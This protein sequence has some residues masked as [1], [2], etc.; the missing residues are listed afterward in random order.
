MSDL[1][2][3]DM[4]KSFLSALLHN[5]D[6]IPMALSIES[7]AGLMDNDENRQFWKGVIEMHNKD[8]SVDPTALVNHVTKRNYL[9]KQTADSKMAQIVQ[10]QESAANIKTWTEVLS[11]LKNRRN[12]RRACTDAK[13][14]AKN[15]K[16]S[17]Q[18]VRRHMTDRMAE[19]NNVEQASL[20]GDVSLSLIERL[21]EDDFDARSGAI[22][23]G[24]RQLDTIFNGI[25]PQDFIGI[26]SRPGWGKSSLM[27]Q[28]ALAMRVLYPDG[29]I[30]VFSMEMSSDE[31]T[32]RFVSQISGVPFETVFSLLQKGEDVGSTAESKIRTALRTFNKWREEDGGLRMYTGSKTPDQVIQMIRANAMKAEGDKYLG[33]FVDNF[34]RLSKIPM[35]QDKEA[36]VRSFKDVTID[37][38]VPVILLF[39]LNRKCVD[40]QRPPRISDAKSVGQ[41]EQELNRAVIID[42]PDERARF[43]SEDQLREQGIKLNE[44][45][46]DVAKNRD[47]E[48]AS[49]KKF[50]HGP[51]MQ[52]LD[53]KPFGEKAPPAAGRDPIGFGDE[54]DVEPAS[55]DEVEDLFS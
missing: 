17:M 26:L 27:V 8:R 19:T 51:T 52:F 15:M 24:M 42:R 40:E 45:V 34:H 46:L 25:S 1:Q 49:F 39:Q 21:E 28:I 4:E 53:E 48:M 6:K 36:A 22:N 35:L 20:L 41:I 5:P 16:T 50:F 2:D 55:E 32:Y 33:A 23:T 30:D 9:D 44:A 3:H 29:I 13:Q 18:E 10:L 31:T 12:I 47:G 54:D 7:S 11:D 43:Q 14:M 38:D 37:K